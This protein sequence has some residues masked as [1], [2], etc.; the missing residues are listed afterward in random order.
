MMVTIC[1]GTSQFIDQA[2]YLMSLHNFYFDYIYLATIIG[3][4]T[5]VTYWIY[6][7]KMDQIYI[8]EINKDNIQQKSI[9]FECNVHDSE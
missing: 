3:P 7:Y 8:T 6:G 9:F 5:I 2:V 4:L 1:A